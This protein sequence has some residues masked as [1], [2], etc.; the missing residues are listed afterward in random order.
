[1]SSQ[2]RSA[3]DSQGRAVKVAFPE[4]TLPKDPEVNKAAIPAW[5]EKNDD[6][7]AE[8]LRVMGTCFGYD[9]DKVHI[10]R[11]IYSP[12][13]HAKDEVEQRAL[14]FF[15]LKVLSGRKPLSTLKSIVPS[16]EEA[17]AFG[18]KLQ[19]GLEDY[20]DGKKDLTVR[21]KKENTEHSNKL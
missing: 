7:L 11:G 16:D 18:R 8:L 10:R 14:R 17:A 3:L 1:M 21:I 20:F 2:H 5:S 15:A 13:G 6:Y 9:F 4:S 19:Q 12:G